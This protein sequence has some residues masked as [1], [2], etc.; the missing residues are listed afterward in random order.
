[1][2]QISPCKGT[3]DQNTCIYQGVK[4]I[5]FKVLLKKEAVKDL[6]TFTTL[7]IPLGTMYKSTYQQQWKFIAPQQ[8]PLYIFIYTDYTRIVVP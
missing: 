1:M 6:L 8:F 2:A 7:D 3:A 4:A 5:G